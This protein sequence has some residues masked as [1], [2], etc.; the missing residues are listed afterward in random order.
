MKQEFSILII[1]AK[2]GIGDGVIYLPFIFYIARKFN[3]KVSLL[4]QSNTR[5]KDLLKNSPFIKEV[6]TLDR[7]DKNKSGRHHGITGIFNL[8]KDLKEKKFSK[9]FTFNSSYRYAFI[10]KMAK[11][12]KRYQYPLGEKKNQNIIEAAKAFI[13][14][15]FGE[16]VESNPK[17][18][19]DND[20]LSKIKN[21]YDF[22]ND[23]K[24]ILHILL[25]CGGSGKTKRIDPKKFVQFM[26]LIEK[27]VNCR[28]VIAAGSNDEEQKIVDSI[29]NSEHNCIPINKMDIANPETLAIIKNCDLA[30]CTDS[31]FSHIAASLDVPTIT[32][33]TDTPMVYVSYHRR[34]HPVLP[35]G[36][37]EVTHNT[38]GAEKIN[39]TDIYIKA[40]KILNL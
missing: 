21:K 36:L 5:A 40:K 18:N 27:D 17:L 31:S 26:D 24:H 13:F 39:P 12:S 11:I 8:I 25:G 33:V 34:M 20:V 2:K 9:S 32:I 29:I 38:L 23:K 16:N 19:V 1:Q 37:D 14:Q 4:A 7:D 15:N 3:T 35:E 30:C 10:T 28:F 22:K 6:I